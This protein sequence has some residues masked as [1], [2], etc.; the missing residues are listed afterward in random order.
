LSS[1]G[2]RSGDGVRKT[3]KQRLYEIA[4]TAQEK[5]SKNKY[6]VNLYNA[7]NSSAGSHF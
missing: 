5:T 4:L 1:A 2:K 7:G 3:T 6:E